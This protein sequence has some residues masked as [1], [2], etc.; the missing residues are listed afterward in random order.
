MFYAKY[1]HYF[2]RNMK[3]SFQLQ[4]KQTNK[5]NK[6][7]FYIVLWIFSDMILILA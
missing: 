7:P 3:C 4:N 2:P 5:K 6:N 1:Y